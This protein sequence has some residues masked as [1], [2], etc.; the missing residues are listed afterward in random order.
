VTNLPACSRVLRPSLS[1]LMATNQAS[2]GARI[3]ISSENSREWPYPLQSIDLRCCEIVLTRRRNP[4]RIGGGPGRAAAAR[5]R[6]ALAP[7]GWGHE[8]RAAGSPA[9]CPSPD[10]WAWAWQATLDPFS[11]MLI[12]G[13][14]SGAFIAVSE[15]GPSERGRRAGDPAAAER[16]DELTSLCARRHVAPARPGRALQRAG[17]P[18]TESWICTGRIR[19]RLRTTESCGHHGGT[20]RF[21]TTRQ[22][23]RRLRLT[24]LHPFSGEM[25]RAGILRF[26][27]ALSPGLFA[28]GELRLAGGLERRCLLFAA[29]KTTN[30]WAELGFLFSWRRKATRNTAKYAVMRS[31]PAQAPTALARAGTKPAPIANPLETRRSRR[32]F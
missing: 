26:V 5:G 14:S 24:A 13:A 6:G 20:A 29:G 30:A 32:T 9:G 15:C 19:P 28:D 22:Q 27:R 8:S 23:Q 2:Y 18:G 17:E 12:D 1:R 21:T 16:S 4:P 11:A 3:A 25:V 7:D 31:A 10:N